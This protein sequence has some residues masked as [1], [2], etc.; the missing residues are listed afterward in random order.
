MMEKCPCNSSKNYTDCCAPFIEGTILAPTAEALMRSRYTAHVKMEID[1][2]MNT[3]HPDQRAKSDRKTVENWAKEADW[4]CLE[5]ISTEKG[6]EVDTV[7]SVIFKAHYKYRNSLKT[8]AEDSSFKKEG[9]QW[10]FVEGVTPKL[11]VIKTAKIGRNDP[12]YCGSGR[13]FKKCCAKK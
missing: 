1:Y 13:K 8:H 11:T 10:Y 3:V 2:I 9:E 5:I 7:G 6:R 4:M 12:C